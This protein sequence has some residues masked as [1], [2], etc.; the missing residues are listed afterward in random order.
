MNNWIKVKIEGKNVLNYIKYLIKNKVNII[1]LNIVNYNK[2]SIIVDYKDYDL[3]NKYSKTYKVTIIK[4]YGKLR[5]FDL[6]KNNVII[7]SCLILSIIFLYL[8]SNIIF[9]VDIMYNSQEIV[10]IVTEELA[11]YDIKK[12]KLKKDYTYLNQVKKKILNDNKDILE[13]IEI[14]ESGTKYIVRLVERK[15][16]TKAEEYQYQSVVSTKEAIITS[17]KAIS[18]EKIKNINDYVKKG[19]TII[20]GI[21]TKPDGTNIYTKAKGTIYGEVW[22]KINIE[23]P[24]YYLEE[25]VTGKNKNVLSFYFLNKKISIFPY[26]KYKQFKLTSKTILE[27]N[28][29]PIR[30]SKEKLY[31]VIIKEEIYTIE[32]AVEKATNYSITKM[33]EKNKS[34]VEIK[35]IQILE[36]QNKN[37]K[38]NLTIF[39][40]AIEDI[41]KIVEIK[42][43][44]NN[45]I[46]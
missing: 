41:T 7:L 42:E 15:K 40:S 37:S 10:N 23:Y 16:E 30:I 19:D 36:K 28:I 12:Y 45:L 18:G 38:I 22:Y 6:I 32:S 33:K 39:V 17:I 27:N 11:K 8:L 26:K 14:E 20:S 3:L 2:L 35:D 9:S 46:E 13:W 5:L 43:E 24:L 1:N 44:T 4:K 21:L 34:I 29:I 25:K 31:E